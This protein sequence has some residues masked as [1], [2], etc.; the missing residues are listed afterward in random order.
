M[1]RK[2]R[3]WILVWSVCQGLSLSGLHDWVGD[4]RQSSSVLSLTW[5]LYV[6]A[7]TLP[8]SLQM[9]SRYR[10]VRLLWFMALG[11]SFIMAGSAAYSAHSVWLGGDHKLYY[12]AAIVSFFQ[13]MTSCW[14]IL[15]PFAEH[16]L[17]RSRWLCDYTLLCR[18]AWGNTVKLLSAALFVG[19]FWALLFLWSGLFSLLKIDWFKDLFEAPTFAYLA[20]SIAFGLGLSLYCTKEDALVNFFRACLT[21]LG[22]LL[23]LTSV[24]LLLFLCA[25]PFQGLAL[26]WKTGYA[27]TLLLAVQCGMVFLFNAA[28]QD[29]HSAI[30]FPKWLLKLIALSFVAMPIYSVLCAY[31]LGLRI[32]QYGW[33]IE[34]VWGACAIFILALYAFG[35]AFISLRR[36]V[37]WMA[38]ARQVN[39]TVALILVLLLL[40]T[41][42]PLLNPVRLTV[43][44]QIDRLLTQKIP[45]DQFDFSYLHWQAGSYG[46]DALR[47]LLTLSQHPQAKEIRQLA[48]AALKTNE[49]SKNDRKVVNRQQLLDALTLY[50]RGAKLDPAFVDFLMVQLK[51]DPFYLACYRSTRS[52]PV[53]VIDLNADGQNELVLLDVYQSRVFERAHGIWQTGG[54]LSS[55][56]GTVVR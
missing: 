55:Y 26:V 50:P 10:S 25:L 1:E 38:G 24:M 15:L 8:L 53:F 27:T 37:V 40:L 32:V 36:Q 20:S 45:V 3:I 28:W 29:A 42:S 4:S 41:H 6:V 34:R 9:L 52:C 56:Q 18:L 47:R 22:W 17:L 5:A 49:Y 7:I 11:F 48:A 33:S 30:K 43:N 51:K 39:I 46:N 14:F 35:Y 19:L 31:S 13:V 16:R 12:A 23:P 44:S 54:A 2:E 21:I